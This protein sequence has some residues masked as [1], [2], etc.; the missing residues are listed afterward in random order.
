MDGPFAATYF[1]TLLFKLLALILIDLLFN[2]VDPDSRRVSVVQN[3]RGR[4]AWVHSP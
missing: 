2:F 3:V 4:A 1:S